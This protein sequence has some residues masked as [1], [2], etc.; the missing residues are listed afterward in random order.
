MENAQK[1]GKYASDMYY[2]VR[3]ICSLLPFSVLRDGRRAEAGD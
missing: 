2:D 3:V 1:V